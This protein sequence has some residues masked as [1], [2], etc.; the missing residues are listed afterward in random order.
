ME[1][2]P[3]CS[4]C[5]AHYRWEDPD[6]KYENRLEYDYGEPDYS[7]V[8]KTGYSEADNSHTPESDEDF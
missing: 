7:Y 5:G 4:H 3:Y 6:D 1:G 2:D 8:P